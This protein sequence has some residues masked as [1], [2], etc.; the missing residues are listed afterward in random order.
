MIHE[1][2]FSPNFSDKGKAQRI[3]ATYLKE[4]PEINLETLSN[5]IELVIVKTKTA[6]NLVIN[7]KLRIQL[8]NLKI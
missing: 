1:E 3:A 8:L 6:T 2:D 7:E 5:L 4:C